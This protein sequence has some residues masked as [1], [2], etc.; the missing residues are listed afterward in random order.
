MDPV[1][2]INATPT[3]FAFSEEPEFDASEKV[4]LWTVEGN[5]IRPSTSLKILKKFSPGV[6][7]VDI[8][9]EIGYYCSKVDVNSDGLYQFDSDI[10]T[11]TLSE[12]N[13]FW[14]KS[15][16]Y[17]N[18]KVVHKRGI[19]LYGA[20]GCG[21]TSLISL[22]CN[23]VIKRNGVI[24]TVTGVNNLTIYSNF[25]KH[26]FREIE[27]DTPVITIIEDLDKYIESDEIL[28]FLD[29]KSQIEHHLVIATSNNTRNI[30]E[31]LTRPSRI[32]LKI[33]VQNPT[34]EVRKNYFKLKGIEES[35]LDSFSEQTDGFSF[36]DIKE[37]YLATTL[38]DYSLED[39]IKKL[40]T[41]TSKKDYSS[42]SLGSSKLAL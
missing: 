22:L 21:K 11:N 6:Y 2:N 13:K 10:I 35:L 26:N 1:L 38:L 4:S 36:A 16:E 9:R 7:K 18:N 37:V 14:D 3:Y 39:A 40:T 31:T 25:L 27:P 32:D 5:I 12:I 33:E 24:F 28:D 29:G 23:E 17:K 20:P 41:K 8:S 19:L 30:P 15:E 42:K 34:F